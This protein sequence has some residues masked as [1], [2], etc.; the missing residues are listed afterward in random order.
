MMDANLEKYNYLNARTGKITT[1]L[2]AELNLI[3]SLV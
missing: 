2:G 1:C 3:S